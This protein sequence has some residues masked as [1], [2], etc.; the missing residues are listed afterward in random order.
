MINSQLTNFN[1]FSLKPYVYTTMEKG[2]PQEPEYVCIAYNQQNPMDLNRRDTS[3]LTVCLTCTGKPTS[4]LSYLLINNSILYIESHVSVQPSTNQS[5]QC[6]T[7]SKSCVVFISLIDQ[8]QHPFLG[9][10]EPPNNIF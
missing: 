4:N 10:H 3:H 9:R 7:P 5:A 8:T 1:V 6:R 2:S